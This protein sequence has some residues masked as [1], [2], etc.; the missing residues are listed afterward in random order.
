MHRCEVLDG[1]RNV[2]LTGGPGTGK[3]HIATALGIRAVA[4]HRRKVRVFPT[5]ERV[6]AG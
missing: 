4:H 2:V 6:R 3:T 5:T 1:T